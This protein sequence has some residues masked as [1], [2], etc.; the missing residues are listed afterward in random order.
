MKSFTEWRDYTKSNE[1]PSDIPFQPDRTYADSGWVSWG[2][3]LGTGSVS[4]Q[5]REYRPFPEARAFVQSL[6]LRSQRE[7][8]DYCKSHKRPDDIPSSP[9]KTY[10]NSGWMSFGDWLG[11]NTVAPQLRRFRSFDEDSCVYS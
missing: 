6:G 9:W 1:T 8:K 7:W 2:D 10:A 4:N 11:T 5:Q 3:W